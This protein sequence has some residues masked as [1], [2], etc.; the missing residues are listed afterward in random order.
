MLEA[1]PTSPPIAGLGLH[2]GRGLPPREMLSATLP[3]GIRAAGPALPAG[4]SLGGER[5]QVERAGGLGAPPGPRKPRAV[6]VCPLGP[7]ERQFLPKTPRDGEE[8][9][10]ERREAAG[11]LQPLG[12]RLLNMM[13]NRDQRR[14]MA[15]DGVL[16]G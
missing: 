2:G 3:G 1:P 13:A 6:G 4:K 5:R 9:E 8:R 16:E 15:W 7:G 10:E 12:S 11:I 14:S